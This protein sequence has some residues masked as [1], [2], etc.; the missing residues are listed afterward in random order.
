[1]IPTAAALSRAQALDLLDA[2]G[3]LSDYVRLQA[4]NSALRLGFGWIPQPD[5]PSTYQQ[6]RGAYRQSQETGEPLPVSSLHC[7]TVIYLW[8]SD[9]VHFRFWHDTSHVELGLSFS[10]EDELELAL[11]HL[12]QIE[13]AGHDPDS[14]PYRL[15][16]ADT[17]GQLL[18]LSLCGRFPLAQSV[19]VTDC[20]RQGLHQALLDEIRRVPLPEP[21]A[22]P[23]P[24]LHGA[25][26]DPLTPEHR[27][28]RQYRNGFVVMPPSGLPSRS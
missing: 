2:R 9:N 23:E 28:E 4:E 6:L 25:A 18:L 27:A 21:T 19:F 14:T 11:W 10:L 8:P 1:M 24:P 3:K 5:A 15:L 20:L 16:E 7:D 13:R 22:L 17:V 26:P 12:A